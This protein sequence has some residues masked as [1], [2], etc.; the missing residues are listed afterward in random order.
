MFSVKKVDQFVYAL[1]YEDRELLRSSKIECE[2][3]LLEY[4][5]SLEPKEFFVCGGVNVYSV[6]DTEYWYSLNLSVGDAQFDIRTIASILV[7]GA[8]F[9][10]EDI[11][12]RVRGMSAKEVFTMAYNNGFVRFLGDYVVPI[13]CTINTA[14]YRRD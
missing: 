13:R 1:V 5:K 10:N 3:R 6:P 14:N 9:L 4:Q 2:R 12:E 8:E 11:L 7:A